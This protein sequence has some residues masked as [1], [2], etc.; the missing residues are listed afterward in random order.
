MIL[1]VYKKGINL[2]NLSI[3]IAALLGFIIMITVCKSNNSYYGSM[4]Q[5]VKKSWT[6]PGDPF[7][8]YQMQDSLSK[9]K[10][11]WDPFMG[12]PEAAFM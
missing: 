10:S 11:E 5:R 6:E 8:Q 9:D 7:K 1:Y 4:F 3:V 12:I 2:K